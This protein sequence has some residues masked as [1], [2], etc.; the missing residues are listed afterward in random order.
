MDFKSKCALTWSARMLAQ[1][2]GVNVQVDPHAT[3]FSMHRDG[4]LVVPVLDEEQE[5]FAL[6]INGGAVHEIAHYLE[7]DFEVL[8]EC[9]AIERTFLMIF[10]DHRIEHWAQNR[11]AGAGIELTGMWRVLYRRN[12]V[13]RP[14]A[15]NEHA[16]QAVGVWALAHCRREA[17]QL[18]LAAEDVPIARQF[19]V[20]KFGEDAAKVV[21]DVLAQVAGLRDTR[22]SL[23][24]TRRLLT[25]LVDPQYQ[26]D[27]AV[28][29]DQSPD[30]LGAQASDEGGQGSSERSENGG[31]GMSSSTSGQA[32]QDGAHEGESDVLGVHE[33]GAAA[34]S[35]RDASQAAAEGGEQ[36]IDA[37]DIVQC[38]FDGGDLAEAAV[39]E[40]ICACSGV[41]GGAQ[42]VDESVADADATN[43]C[44]GAYLIDQALKN[45][46]GLRERIRH[47]LNAATRDD[48]VLGRR[49]KVVP[50]KLWK[51]KTGNANVFRLHVDG[52]SLSTY[53]HVLCDASESMG[54]ARRL[55]RAL[56]MSAALTLALEGIPG[57]ATALTAFPN[58]GVAV[59]RLKTVSETTQQAGD[60]LAGQRAQGGTPMAAAVRAVSAEVLASTAD[61][62][63][64]FIPT[65]GEPNNK[66]EARV[67][68]RELER[69]GVEVVVIGV[70]TSASGLSEHSFRIDGVSDLA[71]AL[72]GYLQKRF[73]EV[74]SRDA[75]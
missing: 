73:A 58:G 45:S 19:V 59:A 30:T 72:F 55:Q 16:L 43:Y 47:L 50:T 38:T 49:G 51:L 57:I 39:E 34:A 64:L 75:A 17:L 27:G 12:K 37:P 14:T 5:D 53:V 60:K 8:D 42:V 11:W 36:H 41:R 62:K 7:S 15:G 56:E 66:P 70:G 2:V 65:D 22:D 1:S 68:I 71:E 10:E 69:K 31:G 9:S 74:I 67:A 61:R 35:P 54:T 48:Q 20:A 25:H 6:L 23:T 44:G 40:L 28:D 18:P 3:T 29:I 21:D 32:S 33:G 52:I 4:T 13:S 63:I 46:M 26:Q 24:L